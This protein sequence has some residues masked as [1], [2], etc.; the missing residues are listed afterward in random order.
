MYAAP[1]RNAVLQEE[2]L[3]LLQIGHQAAEELALERV[4]RGGTRLH[5]SEEHIAQGGY[6]VAQLAVVRSGGGVCGANAR[7]GGV[8]A[9]TLR[10]GTEIQLCVEG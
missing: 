2:R 5:V 6:V 8:A 9:G 1:Q 7:G 10:C 3:R 4:Q